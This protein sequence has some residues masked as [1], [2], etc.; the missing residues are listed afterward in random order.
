M[1]GDR[2]LLDLECRTFARL[3]TRT[4]PNDYLLGSYAEAHRNTGKF[5]PT[6]RFD[7]WLLR[8]ARSGSAVA[9]L[10]DGYARF[11]APRS[12]L[13]RKL[14]LVLS[15]VEV[16]PP[17]YHDADG[18]ASSSRVRIIVALA[19][20]GLVGVAIAG[21]GLIAFGPV[22]LVVRMAGRRP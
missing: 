11:F 14:I 7:P 5:D 6:D 15:L 1:S 13:R 3:F 4:P 22:H 20:R 16:T 17:Y 2:A 19:F 12:L 10:A 18:T 9:R 8:L 21:L